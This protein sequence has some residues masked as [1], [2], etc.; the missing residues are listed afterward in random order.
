[1]PGESN[2]TTSNGDLQGTFRNFDPE[3]PEYIKDLQRPAAIKV[4]VV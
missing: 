3:D 4:F 2:G 1:M